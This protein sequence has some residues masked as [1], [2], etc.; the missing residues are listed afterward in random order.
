MNVNN[1][2]GKADPRMETVR[3]DKDPGGGYNKGSPLYEK[4]EA[5]KEG[6][7]ADGKTAA[8][9]EEE[10]TQI[11][12]KEPT[13]RELLS[14][15]AVYAFFVLACAGLYKY[16]MVQPLQARVKG[17]P[18]SE[19]P[20]FMKCGFVHSCCDCSNVATDWPICLW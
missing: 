13:T 20:A 18:P 4:Q 10:A 1:A 5:R 6:K 19:H 7:V 8:S 12:K 16:G 3:H 14:G 2:V 17:E 15:A 9:V 11:L